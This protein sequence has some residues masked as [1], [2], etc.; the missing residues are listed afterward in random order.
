MSEIY[1]I[2]ICMGSS[3]FSRGNRDILNSVQNFIAR[4]HLNDRVSLRGAH[5]LASCTEGPV[6]IINDRHIANIS[7]SNIEG[8]LEKELRTG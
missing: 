8:I 7:L 6:I 3:C 1:T 4:H 2:T 5:C